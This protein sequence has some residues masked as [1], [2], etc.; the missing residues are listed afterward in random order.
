MIW[1]PA[2]ADYTVED[3]LNDPAL[4]SI[5]AVQNKAVYTF[6]SVLEPWDYP[7]P[8]AA[9]GAA[10]ATYI[11]HPDL[12][13]YDELIADANGLYDLLYGQTFTAEQIGITE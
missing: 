5:T 10:W 6:P 9:L 12:Y 11:L 3:V 8:S 13:T 2:Y 7:T 4:S 1:V